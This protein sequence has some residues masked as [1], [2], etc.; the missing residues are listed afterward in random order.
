MQHGATS[1]GLVGQLLET[2]EVDGV[3][4]QGGS[5][6]EWYEEEVR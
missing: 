5:V 4:A 2:N 1:S 3:G 6:V